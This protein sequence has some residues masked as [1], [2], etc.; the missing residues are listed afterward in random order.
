[1]RRSE[2]CIPNFIRET[3]RGKTGLDINALFENTL[4][5]Y[6]REMGLEDGER[7]KL[8]QDSVQWRAFAR[9]LI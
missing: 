5:S 1:M 8:A 3:A 9:M 4:K 6:L 7:I 2:Y